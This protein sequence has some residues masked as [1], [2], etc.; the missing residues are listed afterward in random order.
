MSTRLFVLATALGVTALPTQIVRW[1]TVSTAL[2]LAAFGAAFVG[3]GR[4]LHEGVDR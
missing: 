4:R 2:L 1:D 3:V